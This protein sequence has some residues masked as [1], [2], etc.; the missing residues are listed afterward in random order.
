[1]ASL[2]EISGIFIR[3]FQRW[4]STAMLSVEMPAIVPDADGQPLVTDTTVKLDCDPGELLS[5][6]EYRFVGQ[7]KNHP[8]YGC[9]F[10]ATSFSLIQPHT[11][12]GIIRYLVHAGQGLRFGPVRAA[13]LY[14]EWGQDAVRMAREK[15]AEVAALLAS[16]RLQFDHAGAVNLSARLGD[17]AALESTTLEVLDLLTGRGFPRATVRD[18]VKEWGADA[19]RRIRRDP[20]KLMKFRGCGFKRCDAMYLELGLPPARLKRQ[21]LAAWYAI[22]SDTDG[23]TW[24]P[25]TVAERAIHANVGGADVDTEKALRLARLGGRL[26]EVQTDGTGAI[27]RQPNGNGQGVGQRWVAERRNADNEREIAEIVAGAMGEGARWPT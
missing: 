4:D 11:R 19:A 1:M 23:H 24:Y 10:H 25:A 17:D 6:Q 15:P 26:A 13:A 16:R 12:Q 21:A 18:V 22:R 9:Q 27:Y 8:K 3:E 20:Y 5:D 7:W 2:V 14:D